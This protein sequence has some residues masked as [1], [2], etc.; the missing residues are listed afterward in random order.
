[1][2]RQLPELLTDQEFQARLRDLIQSFDQPRSN[3]RSELRDLLNSDPARFCALVRPCLEGLSD[4]APACQF[5][6]GLL[7]ASDSFP[8][9]LSD[10]S[11]MSL[12]EAKALTSWMAQ[13]EPALDL[14]LAHWVVHG[15][16]GKADREAADPARILRVLDILEAF[17]KGTRI[18]P[19]LVQLL[20]HPNSKVRSKAALLAG[21]SLKSGQWAERWLTETD[22]RVRANIIE[23]L[24]GVKGPGV[25]D[26]LKVALRDP[27]NRVVGNALV[28]L[29]MLGDPAASELLVQMASH[30]S[31]SFRATAAWAMGFLEDPQFLPTLGRMVHDKEA[32]VRRNALRA[33]AR[34]KKNTGQSLSQIA[35]L[36]TG[37]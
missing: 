18:V 9:V 37:E 26:V 33:L 29:Y 11:L 31:A 16:G 8:R 4:Q 23:S 14:K 10:P 19:I 17:S 6:A 3:A 7:A 27:N 13:A 5:L 21:R 32:L 15:G 2:A 22:P 12:R 30:T 25:M 24:W 20:R 28:G 34:I 36:Q 1:M 35:P